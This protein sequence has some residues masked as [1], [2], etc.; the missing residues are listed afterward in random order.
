[1][2]KEGRVGY[3]YIFPQVFHS[4]HHKLIHVNVCTE[5]LRCA[6]EGLRHTMVPTMQ[7]FSLEDEENS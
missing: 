7:M 5:H 6:I 2:H 3:M 4:D 1:M